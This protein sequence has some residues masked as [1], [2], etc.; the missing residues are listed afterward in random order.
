LPSLQDDQDHISREPP[1]SEVP[2]AN[3]RRLWDWPTGLVTRGGAPGTTGNRRKVLWAGL[4]AT[5]AMV[6]AVNTIDVITIAHNNPG[7]SL[8][9]PII[10]E[11]TAWLSLVVAALIPGF[12]MTYV[13]LESRPI[14]RT[15]LIYIVVAPLFSAIHITGFVALRALI[16]WAAGSRYEFGPALPGFEYE[17]SKNIFGYMGAIA[18]FWIA[19]RVFR[20]EPVGAGRGPRLYDIRD[21]AKLTRVKVDDILAISSA[22]NYVEFVLRDGRKP[23]LRK[24]LSTME[25]EFASEGFVRTHRSWLVNAMQV[26]G[27]K[28]TGSGDY[29]VELG[30]VTVPLSRRFPEAL[31]KLRAG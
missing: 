29:E 4:G 11:G 17:A 12:L 8:A 7:L 30:S 13:P 27:L 14:W 25:A 18:N 21:G 1:I 3:R 28:P 19:G 22:G 31:A 6:G 10:W 9:L 26:T 2:R 20:E 23:M 15:V 16:Y 5:A 24:P